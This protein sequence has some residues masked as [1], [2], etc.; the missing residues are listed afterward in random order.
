MIHDVARGCP[1]RLSRSRGWPVVFWNAFRICLHAPPLF[2]P[3]SGASHGKAESP[4]LSPNR[5]KRAVVSANQLLFRPDLPRRRKSEGG[6]VSKA[7]SSSSRPPCGPEM[8]RGR[9]RLVT[10]MPPCSCAAGIRSDCGQNGSA[11]RTPRRLGSA[12]RRGFLASS[13]VMKSIP[14][15]FL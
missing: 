11:I 9:V 6:R 13:H 8:G 3:M 1:D 12:K 10:C 2:R 7:T 14:A 15:V 5:L 4:R